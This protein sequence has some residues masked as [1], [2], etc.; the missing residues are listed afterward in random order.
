MSKQ[1]VMVLASSLIVVA[2][3]SLGS[4]PELEPA[5]VGGVVLFIGMGLFVVFSVAMLLEKP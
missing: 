5:I 2:G 4:A 3:G 1:K